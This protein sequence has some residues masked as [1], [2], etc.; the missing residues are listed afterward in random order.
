M[1]FE[2]CKKKYYASYRIQIKIKI[3]YDKKSNNGKKI[4]FSMSIFVIP[5]VNTSSTW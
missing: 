5:T 2:S 3:F 4:N 1:H